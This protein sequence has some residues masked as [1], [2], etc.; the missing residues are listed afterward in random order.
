MIIGY[1][2]VI[3]AALE[4]FLGF[5][6]LTRYQKSLTSVCYALFVLGSAV[7]VGSNG[8]GYILH[9]FFWGERMG[10][11]GGV[12]ATT[13]YL[14]FS[15]AFPFPRKK[16]RELVPWVLWP[17]VVFGG[18]VLFTSLFITDQGALHKYGEGYKT[19]TGEYFWFLLIFLVG[20]WTWSITNLIRVH[21]ITGGVHRTLVRYVLIGTLISLAASMI[22]DVT[23]PLIAFSRF[24]YLGSLLN[25]A[26]LGFTAYILVR[27]PR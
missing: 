4:I 17:L 19:A 3:L 13:F 10:W 9:S 5:Y 1:I 16:I 7:Y 8:L 15:F 23:L 6:F 14:P 18:G 11:L 12:L 24:G 21:R 20:Y 26:W 25:F 27:I 2:L 22:F